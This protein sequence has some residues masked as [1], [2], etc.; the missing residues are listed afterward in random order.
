VWLNTSNQNQI[1]TSSINGN[2][3]IG[4]LVGCHK[5]GKCTGNKGSNLNHLSSAGANGNTGAGIAVEEGSSNNQI[6][7]MSSGGNGGS[8]DLIDNNPNCDGNLWFNNTFG[9][10]SQSCIH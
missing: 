6:T 5:E 9:N 4:I 1:F 8:F 2:Q 10:A 7:N 3:K